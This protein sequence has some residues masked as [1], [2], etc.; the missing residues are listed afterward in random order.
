MEIPSQLI[1]RVIIFMAILLVTSSASNFV[2]AS[3]RACTEAEAK[4]ALDQ[5]DQLKGWDAVHRSF[6]HFAH[7]DDGAIAEGYSDTVGRLL[8]R[9]WKHIGDL[10]KLVATDKKFESFVLRHID[11]TLP[12]DTLKTIANNAQKSCHADQ[13]TLCEKILQSARSAST[14]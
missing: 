7:C 9:D 5:T 12:S 11:E 6:V 13:T 14:N 2:A 1:C 8:A 10:A 3:Q 4:Q